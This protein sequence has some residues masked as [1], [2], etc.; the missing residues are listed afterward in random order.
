MSFFFF[1]FFFFLRFV[2]SVDSLRQLSE[3][4]YIPTSYA[5]SAK[6]DYRLI[7]LRFNGTSTL[8]GH[9]V[10]S[11]REKA[12]RDR[13]RLSKGGVIGPNTPTYK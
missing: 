2:S 9:F 8:V 5:K 4:G 12:K 7:V 3:N 11:P 10:S 6:A 1:F 13:S